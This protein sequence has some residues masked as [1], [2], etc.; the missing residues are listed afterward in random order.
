MHNWI[1]WSSRFGLHAAAAAFII[2]NLLFQRHTRQV[3]IGV[4][5]IDGF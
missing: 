5:A 4:M 2:P 1:D 3:G